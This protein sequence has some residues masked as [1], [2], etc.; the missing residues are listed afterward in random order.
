MLVVEESNSKNKEKVV[1]TTAKQEELDPAKKYWT[2]MLAL[3]KTNMQWQ[4]QLLQEKIK[5]EMLKQ[6]VLKKK[7]KVEGAVS[8]E[9]SDAGEGEGDM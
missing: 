7:G 2:E 4:K 5:T 3:Q 6:Y 1:K 8:D 9:E